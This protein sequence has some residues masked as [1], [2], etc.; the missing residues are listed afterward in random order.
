MQHGYGLDINITKEGIPNILGYPSQYIHNQMDLTK[1]C[2]SEFIANKSRDEI[3]IRC[4][5]ET[6]RLISHDIEGW[7][8]QLQ[9]LKKGVKNNE[10]YIKLSDNREPFIQGKQFYTF[11]VRWINDDNIPYDDLGMAFDDYVLIRKG[12]IFAFKTRENRDMSYKYIIGKK[13]C[14]IQEEQLKK[15]IRKIVDTP[16]FLD[17][18]YAVIG[19]SGSFSLSDIKYFIRKN[20]PEM[21]RFTSDDIINKSVKLYNL[22]KTLT[23]LNTLRLFKVIP[24]PL[25]RVSKKR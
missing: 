11:V 6:N 19:A 1:A 12:V 15:D 4:C 5:T 13:Q 24:P 23:R 2:M 17:G 22:N 8:L 9:D 16:E 10:V 18:M 7:T 25:K 14:L 20:R 21:I 3:V